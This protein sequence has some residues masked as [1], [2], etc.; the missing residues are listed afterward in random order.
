VRKGDVGEVEVETDV[1]R[2]A[3]DRLPKRRHGLRRVAGVFVGVRS[4]LE[5]VRGRIACVEQRPQ[6]GDGVLGLAVHDL[7]GGQ[8]MAF[9][10]IVRAQDQG[11]LQGG[12]R[13]VEP[14]EPH[15]ADGVG[16]EG[17]ELGI[18]QLACLGEVRD[19]RRA[20]SFPVLEH[21]QHCV[22][23]GFAGS[24][25][26]Q[27]VE[28]RHGLLAARLELDLGGARECG[29]VVRRDLQRLLERGQRLLLVS[30][31]DE[32]DSLQRPQ[33]GVLGSSAE[34]RSGQLDGLVELSG[35]QRGADGLGRV[36]GC[37]G[38]GQA[39]A[40]QQDDREA[41]F[42]EWS[43]HENT[44][45]NRDDQGCSTSAAPKTAGP[46]FLGWGTIHTASFPGRLVSSSGIG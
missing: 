35:A 44:R 34:R 23:S 16:M 39:A 17:V 11:P 5:R 22:T 37:L 43:H 14:L 6:R 25:L 24:E 8:E 27:A 18:E 38:E 46:G 40:R 45:A 19:G 20:V 26:E 30:L 13:V 15:E 3:Q 2:V 7:D 31:A 41:E 21:R 4:E 12:C 36:L 32:R 10:R 28:E 9:A 1:A 29:D 33:L 42:L